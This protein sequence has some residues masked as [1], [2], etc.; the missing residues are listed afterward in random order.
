MNERESKINNPT[1]YIYLLGVMS[2]AWITFFVIKLRDSF[3][4]EGG[5]VDRSIMEYVAGLRYEYLDKIMIFLSRSGDTLFAIIVTLL[6]IIFFYR[7]S[8]K[9]EANFYAVNIL[10]IAIIS[11]A[12]KYIAK[13]PRPEGQWLVDISGYTHAGGYSFPSGHSMISMAGALILIYFIL[14]NFRNRIF[15]HIV[16]V[17]VFIYAA[18]VGV[19]RIYVGVHYPS[20]VVGGWVIASIWVLITLIIFRRKRKSKVR[21]I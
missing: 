4:A 13:R 20:D 17:V 7:I 15:A 19:S 12:L 3:K 2:L 9:R 8:K 21:Y 5:E 1:Y 18:L 16:S 14:D 10:T 6:I 11:Q